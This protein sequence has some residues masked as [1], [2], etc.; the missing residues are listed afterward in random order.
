M[1]L[2]GLKQAAI[3][4]AMA[5][6][7]IA[8]AQ[9]AA[10]AA[11]AQGRQVHGPVDEPAES[12]IEGEVAVLAIYAK[13][14]RELV[15]D[16]DRSGIVAQATLAYQLPA[17]RGTSLRIEAQA[18]T[19][20][21]A[22]SVRGEVELRQELAENVTLSLGASASERAITLESEETD[23]VAVRGAL[24]VESGKAAIELWG[25]HRWRT[26][27]DSAG[28]KGEGW[29]G[30]ANLRL[31]FGSWHW[32]ELRGAHERIDD[33]AGRHGH[34]RTSFGFDYSRPIAPRLRLLLGADFR[35]WSFDG[36]WIADN[37]ANPR[38][39]DR[40][41]RPEVGLSWGRSKGFFIRGA[42]GYDFHRSNDPR[43]SGDGPRLR[44]IAGFRF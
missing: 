3:R 1:T 42:A 7:G 16:I 38:R 10:P 18:E 11:L 30:G 22:T 32:L 41:I 27:H 29:Q 39:S 13:R 34:R 23:Q 14:D 24:R 2:F 15:S 25:R 35:E 36:R 8:L 17:G 44:L 5:L 21:Y 6:L 33:G 28:G 26:Y 19:D 12:R 43:F 20:K 9:F 31:R 40:L 4:R 37:P